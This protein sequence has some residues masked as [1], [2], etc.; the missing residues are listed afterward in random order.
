MPTPTPDG[1]PCHMAVGVLRYDYGEFVLC[2][3]HAAE[4]IEKEL[5]PGDDIRKKRAD[6]S[7]TGIAI[8]GE[9]GDV[10]WGDI[11]DRAVWNAYRYFARA[12]VDYECCLP[13]GM[14]PHK[15]GGHVHAR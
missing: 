13:Y 6:F 15:M 9:R 14:D 10:M 8:I 1:A 12:Y 11:D 2:D 4:A 3:Y 5:E 7:I